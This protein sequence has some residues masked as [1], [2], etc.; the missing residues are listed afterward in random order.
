VECFEKVLSASIE[1]QDECCVP[2]GMFFVPARLILFMRMFPKVIVM[3]NHL[4]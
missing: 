3:L 1:D 2:V 4:V